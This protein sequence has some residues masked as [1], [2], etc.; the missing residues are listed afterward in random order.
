MSLLGEIKRRKVFQVAAVYL[1]VAWLIMQVV[2]V[3]NEP[4][5]L[6]EWFATVAILIVA[7]GFPI[8]LI[9]S[10]AFDLTPE[11]VV[12][13]QGTNVVVQSRGRRIEYILIGLLVVSV[14]WLTYR[15]EITTSEPA[16]DVVAEESQRD[17]LP[18]SIAV[19]L[20]DNLSPDPDNAYFAAGIHEEILNH[21]VKIRD[22]NVIARTSVLQYAGAARPI[23]EI[24]QELNVG[25]IMECSVS[26]AEDRV[27]ITAQL[28]DAE[29]GVH[30]WSERYNRQLADIFGIQADIATRIAIALEAE[31]LPNERQNIERV[32]TDSPEAYAMYLRAL[33]AYGI[34][35][36]ISVSHSESVEFHRYLD[37]A[38]EFD[39]DFALAYA[40][41]ARDYAYSM[42]RDRRLEETLTVAEIETLA[43]ENA[44]R[45]LA[46]DPNLGL[47]HAALAVTNRF[48]RRW[49]E[50]RSGYERALEY[51]PND[52]V[53]LF[54]FTVFNRTLGRH[55][56]A[57][58]LAERLV[59]ISPS[60]GHWTLGF[61]LAD[62]GRYDESVASI[63]AGLVL[64]PT[65]SELYV[66]LGD[67]EALRGNSAEA[68]EALR[69]AEG[70]NY[71]SRA[72]SL[73]TLL[74][75]YSRIGRHEDVE[76]L[77]GELQA[78]SREFHIGPGIWAV[79]YLSLGD[80][81]KALD[82]L[83]RAAEQPEPGNGYV[84][85]YGIAGNVRANPI[86]DQPEFVEV[87]RR[88]GF[89]E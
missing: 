21:L 38:I 58:R 45:A 72:D 46:F 86:L 34:G 15:V 2:D 36:G 49:A 82:W 14:G 62:G 70:L 37:Q 33:S 74:R 7:I 26:Y 87:R 52:S 9:T 19:L 51:S 61:I 8:A 31:L 18:N 68:L 12:Q 43:R 78:L 20:C 13:D 10:W 24:A 55:Q 75:S 3:V 89:R 50:A 4:L 22:L 73:A 6:P 88:L 23:T 59:E 44:E 48:N 30:L 67:S 71:A 25:S 57:L 27:A 17:V 76:R 85:L 42:V 35:T 5:R 83:N 29:T 28:I 56:D 81:E 84:A 1:V 53:I 69:I 54:D 41:K 40:A 64:Y 80:Q 16:I 39:P 65:S 63:Q 77:F 60:R 11:G 66:N 79:A 47:A 32:P